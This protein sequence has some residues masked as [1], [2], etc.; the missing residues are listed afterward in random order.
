MTSAARPRLDHV[1]IR[2]RPKRSQQTRGSGDLAKM[3]LMVLR[4]P[5][6]KMTKRAESLDPQQRASWFLGT[7]NQARKGI[8]SYLSIYLS[9][10][11]LISRR[12]T[13][14]PKVRLEPDLHSLWADFPPRLR[15]ARKFPRCPGRLLASWPGPCRVLAVSWPSGRVLALSWPSPGHVPARPGLLAGP[16]CSCPAPAAPG[17]GRGERGEGQYSNTVI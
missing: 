6:R 11:L 7:R 17:G 1:F 13:Q 4:A 14:I 12:S 3:D 10:Y 16:G 5:G 8:R 2:N 9:I 15:E